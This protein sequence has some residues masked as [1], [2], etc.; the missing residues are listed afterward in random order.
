MKV[1]IVVLLI[2]IC[3]THVAAHEDKPSSAAHTFNS[4]EGIVQLTDKNLKVALSKFPSLLV[5]F[6]ANWCGVCKKFAPKFTKLAPEFQTVTF[7]KINAE[8]NEKSASKYDVTSYPTIVI[9]HQDKQYTF[10]GG[11]EDINELKN[12]IKRIVLSPVIQEADIAAKIKELDKVA[13]LVG[14][15]ES[16][17]SYEAFVGASRANQYLPFYLVSSSNTQLPSLLKG[18]ESK[19]NIYLFKNNGSQLL[20]YVGTSSAESISRFFLEHK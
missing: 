1:K 4:Q 19:H 11:F 8:G 18:Q 7:S 13:V 10:E 16:G 15:T 9:F 2:A 20:P 12:F 14:D 17:D 6:Y 5:Y 3:A